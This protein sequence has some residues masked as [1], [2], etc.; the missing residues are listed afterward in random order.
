MSSSNKRKAIDRIDLNLLAVLDALLTEKSITRAANR[1]FVSQP[2][3]SA[4]LQKLR[5]LF[6]DQLMVRVGRVMELTPCAQALIG[7]VRETLLMARSVF[8]AHAQFEPETSTR[9]FHIAMS[10][11]CAMTLFPWVAR[12]LLAKG[13]GI[14]CRVEAIDSLQVSFE[15]LGRGDIDL[16]IAPWDLVLTDLSSKHEELRETYLYRDEF[17][18]VA[19]ADHPITANMTVDDYIKS[20]HAV[21]YFRGEVHP[22]QSSPE[23]RMLGREGSSINVGF[24]MPSFIS[25]FPLLPGTP[26]LA[27]VPRHLSRLM[28]Q[29]L[30]LRTLKPPIEFPP[31]QEK[32]IW[33]LRSDKDPGHAWMRQLFVD[34]GA[35]LDA[36]RKEFP[37][38]DP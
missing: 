24:G 15:R 36:K 1:L 3:V 12:W 5:D 9:V 16:L 4:S 29:A 2:A 37:T 14:R 10:D 30:P 22:T 20:P 28:A 33:H 23:E 13:P 38:L 21:A 32:L 25:L 18:F 34:A 27:L 26:L 6:D 7:P 8:D 11:Y 31:V 19:S 17:V 35:E